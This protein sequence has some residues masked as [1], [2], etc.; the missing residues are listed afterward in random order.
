MISA[1]ARALVA[2]GPP[3]CLHRTARDR[4]VGGRHRST[5]IRPERL[6]PPTYRPG[7]SRHPARSRRLHVAECLATNGSTV[8]PRPR[9]PTTRD[10]R[11]PARRS[12]A[13]TRRSKSLLGRA[14][15]PSPARARPSGLHT[16]PRTAHAGERRR[17]EQPPVR[18][19]AGGPRQPAPRGPPR[20]LHTHRRRR[21]TCQRIPVTV[22]PAERP[23]D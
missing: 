16:R 20:D 7:R 14:P 2:L 8:G 9:L 19:E 21:R 23:R 12:A 11:P 4:L 18:P 10:G 22:T 17:R 6:P 1:R 3:S 13:H 15:R 5:C